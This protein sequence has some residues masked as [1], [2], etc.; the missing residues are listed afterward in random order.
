MSQ[1]QLVSPA[2]VSL[3]SITYKGNPVVTTEMLATAYECDVASI[4]Q[5]FTRNRDRFIE[6]KHFYSLA[7]GELKDFRDSVTNCHAVV[8]A[9]TRNLT[10]WLE[11]GAA[12]H[13][14]MLNTDR[15]WDVFEM[16][17]ETFF[18]VVKPE[19]PPAL[20]STPITPDQ[21]CTLQAMV[22]GL[23]D[24]GGIYANIWS[25]FNNHFRIGSYKQLPA[26][27]MSEAVE[28]LMAFDV[29]PKALPSSGYD[30][31]KIPANNT[32]RQIL[33]AC[34]DALRVRKEIYH[35]CNYLW[36]IANNIGAAVGEIKGIIR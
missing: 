12:R 10:L 8:P 14:K 2:P 33:A 15:A 28:Y 32:K 26:S 19:S 6:G 36:T 27:R 18:R 3:P 31:S 7:N 11:R 16:L 22:K 17:E 34:D 25:R 30:L 21:Q 5:N 13:A 1:A 29:T 24:K 4:R 9:R 23:V 35:H 20:P